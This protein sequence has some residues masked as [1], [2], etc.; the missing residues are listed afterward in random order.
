M[1]AAP[2][3][4]KAMMPKIHEIESN[5]RAFG[6]EKGTKE[7]YRAFDLELAFYRKFVGM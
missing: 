3:L 1:N 4:L 5:L 2:D 6:Y 7:W